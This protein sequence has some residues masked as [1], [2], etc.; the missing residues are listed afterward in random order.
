MVPSTMKK[1][2]TPKLRVLIVDEHPFIAKGVRALLEIEPDIEIVGEA[3]MADALL[4]TAQLVRYCVE[5]YSQR[6]AA[7]GLTPMIR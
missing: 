4:T 3:R 5:W 6:H 1:T 2:K 7:R